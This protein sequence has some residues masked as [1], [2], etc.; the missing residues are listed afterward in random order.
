MEK[1]QQKYEELKGDLLQKTFVLQ[2]E[3]RDNVANILSQSKNNSVDF[4]KLIKD[5]MK[6]LTSIFRTKNSELIAQYKQA[7][8]TYKETGGVDAPKY[9]QD[10]QYVENSLK[11]IGVD[12][13]TAMSLLH[14]REREILEVYFAWED[15]RKLSDKYDM[16]Y[17][18]TRQVKN[19]ALRW[20]VEKV[21]RR[22]E[23]EKQKKM[24]LDSLGMSE[25]VVIVDDMKALS[26]KIRDLFS[27]LEVNTVFDLFAY[28]KENYLTCRDMGVKR[29]DEIEK[30][31][32]YI[33][34]KYGQKQ[35]KEQNQ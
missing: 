35:S 11:K 7:K 3:M 19:R 31:K 34:E 24:I 10:K 32:M 16:A 6:E 15:I 5:K 22:Q 4:E 29:V 23:E 30:F 18:K 25:D 1:L 27:I 28:T 33:K 13:D 14:E 21:M 17:K 12:V 2:K 8:Q 26:K 9:V 20:V